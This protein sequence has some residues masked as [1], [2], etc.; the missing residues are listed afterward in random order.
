MEA[1]DFA[2]LMVAAVLAWL[3]VAKGDKQSVHILEG[4]LHRLGKRQERANSTYKTH[5]RSISVV[6]F[7]AGFCLICAAIVTPTVEIAVALGIVGGLLIV[8][9]IAGRLRTF[10][11]AD[12]E[13]T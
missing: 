11:L 5:S 4:K 7:V 13:L 2:Y 12:R 8:L 3:I 9:G 6:Q 1:R 10:R